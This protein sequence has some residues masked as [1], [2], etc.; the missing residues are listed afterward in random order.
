MEQGQWTRR[1]GHCHRN[2]FAKIAWVLLGFLYTRHRKES[3]AQSGEDKSLWKKEAGTGITR[4]VAAPLCCATLSYTPHEKQGESRMQ[5][6]PAVA[7]QTLLMSSY[8]EIA[9]LLRL[10]WQFPKWHRGAVM[11][12]CWQSNATHFVTRLPLE[13]SQLWHL[14]LKKA[15]HALHSFPPNCTR[16]RYCCVCFHNTYSHVANILSCSMTGVLSWALSC[17]ITSCTDF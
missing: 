9:G 1:I 15:S 4:L 11:L 5:R 3:I 14:C 7:E 16:N 6:F 8:S 2:I 10:C 12:Q 17:M 13:W